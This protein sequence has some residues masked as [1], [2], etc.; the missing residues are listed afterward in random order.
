MFSSLMI[1]IRTLRM[2]ASFYAGPL[3]SG[4]VSG[5]TNA[6]NADYVSTVVAD[7]VCGNVGGSP[8]TWIDFGSAALSSKKFTSTQ[9]NSN[10]TSDY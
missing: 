1:L 2:Y 6:Q 9:L 10:I 4:V 7:S 5:L 3:T 8:S